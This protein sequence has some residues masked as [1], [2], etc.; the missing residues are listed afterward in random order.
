MELFAPRTYPLSSAAPVELILVLAEFGLNSSYALTCQTS[1]TCAGRGK[2]CNSHFRE[3]RASRRLKKAGRR[4]KENG[5]RGG[6]IAA[7]EAVGGQM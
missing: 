1:A 4:L 5:G 6:R 7:W 3:F 2:T